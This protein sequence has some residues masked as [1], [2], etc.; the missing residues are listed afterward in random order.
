VIYRLQDLI[1]MANRVQV[2]VDGKYVPARP[3]KTDLDRY[4]KGIWLVLR[5]KA[6]VVVW[7]ANQ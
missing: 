5:G 2:C 3:M 4:W 1:K 6:D 7:P